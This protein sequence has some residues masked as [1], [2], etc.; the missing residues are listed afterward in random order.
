ML[1]VEL[2]AQVPGSGPRYGSWFGFWSCAGT[3]PSE[4]PSAAQIA[5]QCFIPGAGP[6]FL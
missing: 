5:G 2:L 6:G 1:W 3:D 4:G